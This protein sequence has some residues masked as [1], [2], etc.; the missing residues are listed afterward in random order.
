MAE[1]SPREKQLVRRPEES[2]RKLT[3]RAMKKAAVSE[4]PRECIMPDAQGIIINEP[5]P[6]MF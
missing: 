6:G 2:Q 3:H 1:A 5:L 4:T